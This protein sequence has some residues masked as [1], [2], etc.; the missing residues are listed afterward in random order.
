LE[1]RQLKAEIKRLEEKVAREERQVRA[2]AKNPKMPPLA[3]VP[4]VCKDASCPPPPPPVF[5]SFA[6]GLQVDSWD[7]AFSF[8]IGGR[9]LID[10]G[11]NSQPVEVFP[12]SGTT[13]P[14]GVRPYLPSHPGSG[15]SNQIGMRQV[16]LEVLGKPSMIGNIS[17]NMTSM[18]RLTGS[19]SAE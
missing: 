9:V 4:I 13:L 18:V 3:D 17:F 1:I 5:V 7:D 8:R 2:I 14:A 10:G 16:R 15:F 12:P 19:P 6:N 11:V